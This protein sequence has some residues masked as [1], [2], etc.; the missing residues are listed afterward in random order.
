MQ[1]W[2]L[3]Y[4]AEGLVWLWWAQRG[5]WGGKEG[6]EVDG[7]GQRPQGWGSLRTGLLGMVIHWDRDGLRL[8]T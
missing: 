2:G 6:S 3:R 1:G 5:E 7:E 4:A 8:G